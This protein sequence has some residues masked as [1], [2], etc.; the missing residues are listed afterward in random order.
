MN[1]C[2][3][4]GST[5]SKKL[6]LSHFDNDYLCKSCKQDEKTL[7]QDMILL[8]LDPKQYKGCGYI[9]MIREIKNS[10]RFLIGLEEMGFTRVN[11]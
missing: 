10:E 7:K 11:K 5:T 1:Q 6:K 9:P 3:R 2:D 8:G 4:C